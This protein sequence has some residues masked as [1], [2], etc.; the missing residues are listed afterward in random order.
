M[1]IYQFLQWYLALFFLK[2][3]NKEFLLFYYKMLS[4]S[5]KYDPSGKRKKPCEKLV[6]EVKLKTYISPYL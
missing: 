1:M 2:P 6:A 5:K 4:E 3:E